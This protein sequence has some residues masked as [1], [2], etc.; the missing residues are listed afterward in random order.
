MGEATNT[1]LHSNLCWHDG[2]THSAV[3][4][5]QTHKVKNQQRRSGGRGCD[6]QLEK[7]VWLKNKLSSGEEICRENPLPAFCYSK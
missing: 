7:Y 3:T 4:H 6:K 1:L 5:G 2:Q